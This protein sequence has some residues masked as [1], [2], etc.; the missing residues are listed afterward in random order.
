LEATLDHVPFVLRAEVKEGRAVT[1]DLAERPPRS[2]VFGPFVLIPGRQMLLKGDAPVRIGS[3]ALDILITLVERP[4]QLVSKSELIARVWPNTFVDESNLKVNVSALRRALGDGGPDD[5]RYIA[6]VT[7][8]GYR[9]VAPVATGA[10]TEVETGHLGSTTRQHNLPTGT[11]RILGRADA[12]DAIRR[13]FDVSRL[14]TIVGPGGVGKTTVALAVAEC[15]I[16]SFRDGVWLV[17]FALLTDPNHAPNAIATAV[18][19]QGSATSSLA[20]LCESLRDRE[21]LLVL[22]NCEHIIDAAASCTSQILAGAARVKILVTSRETLRLSGERVRRLSGLGTPPASARLSAEEALTYPAVQLFVDRATDRLESFTLSDADAPTV[23]EICSRLDGLA[24]AIEFA[25][26]RIDA[27]GV[28]GLLKQLDDRFRLLTGLR[29]GPGRHR[30]L[31]ATLDWSYGL[32]STSE[33]TLLRAVS[34][35]SGVFD[36]DGASAVSTLAPHEVGDTLA[37]LAA[38]SLLVVDIDVDG[39]AYRLLETTRAYCLERRQASGEDRGIR[40]RHAEHVCMVLERATAEWPQRPAHDWATEYGRVLD[41]LRQS[42]AWAAQDS[43]DRSLRIRLTVAGLLLWN[44]LSL[45]EEC[46]VH[47][48][49]AIEDLDAAH[50][51]GTPFEMHLKVWLGASAMFTHGLQPLA[52]DA[53]QRA[54]EI[55]VQLG[56]ADYRLRCLRMIAGYELF[57]GKHDAAIRTLETFVSV[58]A[59]VDRSAVPD[60]ETHL[61]IAE[62]FVGRLQSSRRRLARLYD[63]DLEGVNDSRF[64]R[65]LYSRNVDVGNVLSWAQWLT[66]SPDTAARTAEATVEQA[67]KTRHDLSLSNALAVAAC[68]VFFSSGRYQECGRYVAMLDEQVTR[69]GIVL[70]RPVALFYRGALAC[71]QH[72]ASADGVV[73]LERAVAEFR[74]INHWARMPFILCVLAD[75]LAKCGRL[76]DAATTIHAALDRVHAQNERWCAPEVL[77]IQASILTAEG[78]SDDAEAIL[79]ESMALARDIGALS[80]QLRSANDLAQLWLGLSR[81]DDARKMLRAICGEF[82]EGFE[83]RDLVGAANLLSS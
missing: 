50:L 36:L 57:L 27:F 46:R 49:Q 51:A 2:F 53:M 1:S 63:H 43:I 48:S 71:A 31:T 32:L 34:V 44:H 22:D 83:T 15:A 66:G 64:A 17:D 7:G 24:L 23:A 4:G 47:V 38:K 54:L 3:R 58:A 42:L 56:D 76:A 14:V 30:T 80:W 25:A 9:F 73:D 33:A 79:V 40:Q 21:M 6:T 81:A 68:P 62:I 8:Q 78:R 29:A 35:F 5:A 52:M 20:A 69:R 55:A 72:D 16:G 74:A 41:D 18:G 10:L 77:R 37:Q 45:T 12:I 26:T 39:A 75:A 11:T 28:V 65:F 19:L 61:G 13:D 59:T 82:T 70:W 60:G 67:L